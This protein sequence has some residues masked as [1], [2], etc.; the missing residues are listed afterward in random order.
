M[1]MALGANMALASVILATRGLGDHGTAIALAVTARAAFLWFFA[2][3]TGGALTTLFGPAFLPIKLL[4]R[5]LGLAF[6]AALL[7]HL[8]LVGWL[9]WIGAA[10]AIGVFVFFGPVAVLTFVLAF[11]SIGNFHTILGPRWWQLL[12]LIGMNVILCTFL[13]DFLQHPLH[14]GVR[15]LIEYLPFAAMAIVAPLLRFAAWAKQ[16]TGA[17]LKAAAPEQ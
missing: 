6:A 7:I 15:H 4:G 3:Y 10:P 17:G 13:K 12:R 8:I 1:V 2:A 14:G 16:A 9:C 5:E 11:F